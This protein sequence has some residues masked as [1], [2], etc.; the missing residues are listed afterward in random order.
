MH[1][2]VSLEI[3]KPLSLWV[4]IARNPSLTDPACPFQAAIVL[5]QWLHKEDQDEVSVFKT[6]TFKLVS[7]VHINDKNHQVQRGNSKLRLYL[8]NT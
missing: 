3:S 4:A 1:A 2:L 6:R 7:V 5:A 8:S